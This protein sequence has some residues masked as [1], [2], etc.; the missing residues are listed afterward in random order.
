[1]LL[2]H[3][4]GSQRDEVGGM[5]VRLAAALGGIGVASLRIDFP[6]C[7]RSPRPQTDFTISSEL[8]DAC[9]AFQW[10]SRQAGIDASRIAVVGFSQGGVIAGLLTEAEPNVAALVAWSS[11]LDRSRIGIFGQ[12]A[13]FF[14]NDD[15]HVVVDL[16]FRTFTFSRTW[17]EQVNRMDL[18]AAVAGFDRPVLAIAAAEDELVAP[19]ASRTL[20]EAVASDDTT[21]VE[22]PGADHIFNVIDTTRDVSEKVI[23]I[24]VD[25]L[26][27]RL[28][29]IDP[30]GGE[31]C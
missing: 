5:F 29:A 3:G 2:L 28:A 12:L 23:E 6:G 31:R 24:T 27:T 10:L 9:I 30:V 7:G 18:A 14:A 4:T 22:I 25:W 21:Y 16:G 1:V 13:P 20:L 8:S 17:W 15:D 11:G 26:T 19:S